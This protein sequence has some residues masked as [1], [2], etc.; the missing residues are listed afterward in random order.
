MET[1]PVPPP[2]PVGADTAAVESGLQPAPRWRRLIVAPIKFLLGMLLVQSPLGAVILTGWTGRLMERVTL[3]TWWRAARRQGY[4]VSFHQFAQE[5]AATSG[6]EHWPNWFVCQNFAKTISRQ[7]LISGRLRAFTSG[8]FRS[9]WDNGRLGVQM[10]LNTALV[11]LPS[12]L[13]MWSGWFTGWQI[14]FNKGYEHFA[15]GASVSWLGILL[16]IAGMFYVPMALARQAATGDWRR[17]Y[18]F[19]L[20]RGLVKRAWLGHALLAAGYV[21]ASFPVMVMTA[22]P[23]FFGKDLPSDAVVSPEEIRQAMRSYYFYC[24][25]WI[26][27][28][29]VALRSLSAML[30]ARTLVKAVQSGAVSEE[31]LTEPE[32]KT[33]HR[34]NLLNEVKSPNRSIWTRVALWFGTRAGRYT[35]G[36]LTAIAWF[37]VLVLP[38]YIGTFVNYRFAFS[39][40][41]QPLVL[42]PWFNHLPAYI[43]SQ[44]YPLAVAALV[45][46]LAWRAS[47]LVRWFKRRSSSDPVLGRSNP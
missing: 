29:F 25:F 15:V 28:A 17:F 6:H 42:L 38:T 18:D 40:L 10:L 35:G 5:D 7:P 4:S 26:L 34:L 41:N 24:A 30:Y 37:G 19:K 44:W 8:L 20:V 16:F 2:L 45:L 21:A 3:R 22:A 33:L 11:I 23:T 47:R 46:F 14:S 39:W 31:S 12:L 27:P 1:S 13:L 9:A 32:W 36:I 43:E